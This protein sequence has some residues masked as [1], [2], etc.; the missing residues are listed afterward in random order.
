MRI[1]SIFSIFTLLISITCYAT[2][3]KSINNR[4]H[5]EW[6]KIS[7]TLVVS[8]LKKPTHITHAGDNSGRLFI[9]EQKG[10]I[11]IVKNNTMLK[12]PFLEISDRTSCCGERGLLSVAFPHNYSY[13]KYFYVN[14]TN[15]KG[16]TV[17]ARY[18]LTSNPDIADTK[19]EE[20]LLT[21]K[22]PYSN[23]NGGQLGFGP[24]GYLYIGMGDGGSAGDPLNNGQNSG[25]LLGKI[26]R[27]DVESE[28]FPYAVPID[29]PFVKNK[30]YRPEIWA[31]GLRNPWRF[32]FDRK[33]GDLYI[34]DVG[35]D[36][37]EEINFQSLTSPGGE[38]YGWNI[39]EGTHCYNSLHCSKA[40]LVLPIVEYDHSQGCSVTGGTVYRGKKFPSLQG[41]YLYSDYCSGRIW[42]LKQSGTIWLNTLL[43]NSRLSISSF[44]ENE[45]GE[46]F[47]ADYSK[48]NIYRIKA[49]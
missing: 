19:R 49:R 5:K 47:L 20:I 40:G 29:N 4:L 12:K 38:N 7:L 1:L 3:K 25:S 2:E 13:K 15:K 8:G 26:L 30:G 27:I 44:G 6:P 10:E 48:G 39:L 9:S 24:D 37:Y 31:L 32:S 34:A 17:I 45:T 43:I 11:F 33:T 28:I 16:S 35:Q 14:Y 36:Q 21:L 22:Q 41:I 18:K 46:I 42:G 23:H